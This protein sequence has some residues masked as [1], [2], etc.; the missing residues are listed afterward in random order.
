MIGNLQEVIMKT[1]LI[2]ASAFGGI[3]ALD[4]IRLSAI[5]LKKNMEADGMP[6]YIEREAAIESII[7]EPQDA[8]YPH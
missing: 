3:F 2:A 1:W 4:I 5:I 7:S 6:K 8:H